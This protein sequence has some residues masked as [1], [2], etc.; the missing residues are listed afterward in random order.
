[1]SHPSLVATTCE[2]VEL[3]QESFLQ[4]HLEIAPL[5]LRWRSQYVKHFLHIIPGER[6]L[7]LGAGSGLWTGE[8]ADA[9]SYENEIVAAV[10]SPTLLSAAPAIPKAEFVRV[11]D[12]LESLGSRQ[13]DYVIGSTV[14]G[15][16]LSSE[17]LRCLYRVLKPG[18]Q[19]FFF[20]P[21][22]ENLRLRFSGSA[23]VRSSGL[24]RS[25]SQTKRLCREAGFLDTEVAPYDILPW[26]MRRRTA[27]RVQAKVI[28]LEHAPALKELADSQYLTARKPGVRATRLATSLTE[29][30]S[31]EGAVS[32][33]I[34][35]HNEAANIPDLTSQL[36]AFYSAYIKEIL[37]VNDNSSDDT[38]EVVN[39]LSDR[40][41]RIKVINRSKPNGVGRALRDGYQSASGRYILSMDCDFVSLL[42]EL[43]GLFDAVAAGYEGA[44]GSRFSHDSVILNYPFLKMACN[45]LFH[46]LIRMLVKPGVRD[47]TNNLKLYR[48][49]IL[50]SLVIRS[51]HF[52]ANL[53]T[54]LKP[55][56]EGYNIREVPISWI[57]R[58]TG[59]GSSSFMLGKVGGDYIRAF[60]NIW[61]TYRLNKRKG[62]DTRKSSASSPSE[63]LENVCKK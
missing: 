22:V 5:K 2:A 59:M 36:L 12:D 31:L 7:Q 37:I 24:L 28:L 6:I 45:R 33:V 29:H 34:P 47:V 18:G 42:P 51:P 1:M 10:F 54:G 9:L 50:K 13:F 27:L 55:L 16:A 57:D 60:I 11:D 44:I 35:C 15:P 3:A 61:N 46:L 23:Q 19:I 63:E 40:D 56:L 38:A 14:A 20:E 26:S 43:R 21:N 25:R 52:S 8:L 41:K 58:T 39:E 17:L 62:Q 53:E 48:A 4:Q 30:K 49:D 32:V